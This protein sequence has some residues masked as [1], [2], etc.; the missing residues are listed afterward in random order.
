MNDMGTEGSISEKNV[1]VLNGQP[2]TKKIL[3]LPATQSWKQQYS[4]TANISIF[5]II[6]DYHRIEHF[7]VFDGLIFVTDKHLDSTDLLVASRNYVTKIIVDKLPNEN[8]VM[9]RFSTYLV[10]YIFQMFISS[11]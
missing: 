6:L 9:I 11:L 4:H 10:A 1:N 8:R 5:K 7:C 2:L 3:Y